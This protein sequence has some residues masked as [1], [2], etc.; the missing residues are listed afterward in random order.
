MGSGAMG[1]PVTKALPVL[2][3]PASHT[4][5]AVETTAWKPRVSLLAPR[6]T[7]QATS[8]ASP[9]PQEAAD[10]SLLDAYLTLS[11]HFQFD[12]NTYSIVETLILS[13]HRVA[14]RETGT[15]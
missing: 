8:E 6:A 9:S 5:L 10:G 12:N 14:G 4:T 15:T 7:T 1:L 11:S 2:L 13:H 3:H